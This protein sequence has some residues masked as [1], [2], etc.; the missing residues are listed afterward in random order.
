MEYI[1][2]KEASVKWGI[3]ASR[4]GILVNEGRIPG[5][6]HFGRSWLIPADAAKP[7]PLKGGRTGSAGKKDS[8]AFPLYH[9]RPDW[10]EVRTA[11]LTEQQRNL[12]LA[13]TAFLECRYE[14]AYPM[15]EA[16]LSAPEDIYTEIGALWNAGMCCIALNK[17]EEF[18][19][20]FLRLK[21]LLSTNFPHRDDLAVILAALKTYVDP[22]GSNASSSVCPTDIHLQ[23]LPTACILA[24]YSQLTKEAMK[25]GSADVTLL[26]LNLH[27]LET[28]SC[29]FAIEMLHIYL[30]GIYSFR[31]NTAAVE[32]HV[33]AV[34]QLAYESKV[35]FPLVSYY[36]Y[37]VSVLSPVLDRYPSEFQALCREQSSQYEK[38]FTFFI[39]SISE[40]SVLSKL[41]E[42]DYPY[43]FSV[44]LGLTN[45]RIA[46]ELGVSIPTVS[47]KLEKLCEKLG[48]SDKKGLRD[49]LR[50][51]L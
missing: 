33:N 8:F 22:I 26:E 15:L 24:G 25:P 12:L 29:V 49:Y 42:E 11:K 35:Y 2:I 14:A 9:L 3:S 6:K 4:I 45:T 46:K 23:T 32:K 50:N 40:N 51:F 19:R 1:T 41:T 39:A 38:N 34:V 5:A 16:I 7:Q 21:L 30:L 47:R 36:H 43:A 27:L 13:E 44:L 18:S 20:F 48:V 37:G 28:T 31:K 17:A 10:S